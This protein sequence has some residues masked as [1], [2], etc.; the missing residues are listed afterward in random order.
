MVA[1]IKDNPVIGDGSQ[2]W[3]GWSEEGGSRITGGRL[4]REQDQTAQGGAQSS[5]V[6]RVKMVETPIFIPYTKDSVLRKTL[7]AMDNLVGETTNSPA[8]RFVERCGG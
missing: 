2:E 6:S 1:A 8:A 7:Q 3:T 5:R 4:K